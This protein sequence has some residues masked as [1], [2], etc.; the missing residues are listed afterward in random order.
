MK[1]LWEILLEHFRHTTS[2]R[3]KLSIYAIFLG[4]VLAIYGKLTMEFVALI[5]AVQGFYVVSKTYSDVKNGKNNG[6]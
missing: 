4:F 6:A 2:S 3:F 5:S 1:Q